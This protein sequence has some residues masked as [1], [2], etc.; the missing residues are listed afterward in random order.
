MAERTQAVDN[1]KKSGNWLKSALI[2]ARASGALRV[3]CAC[4][5]LWSISAVELSAQGDIAHT[6][7]PLDGPPVV[8]SQSLA[9]ASGNTL[10]ITLTASGRG[11][12][13]F[14]FPVGFAGS[15]TEFPTGN[16]GGMFSGTLPNLTYTPPP[17]YLGI[18]TLSYRAT[19]FAGPGQF[20][21]L[22]ITV[23]PPGTPQETP[24]A[25]KAA[26][27]LETVVKPALA[28]EW[29]DPAK[30]RNVLN[31]MQ[32]LTSSASIDRRDCK[33]LEELKGINPYSVPA[34]DLCVRAR[35]VKDPDPQTQIALQKRQGQYVAALGNPNDSGQPMEQGLQDFVD[36]LA[37]AN[38]LG[39]KAPG[40]EKVLFG[41]TDSL[42]DKIFQD[43]IVVMT[44]PLEGA[45][46]GGSEYLLSGPAA[47]LLIDNYF[48]AKDLDTAMYELLDAF[49][50][51]DPTIPT[52]SQQYAA[53]LEDLRAAFAMDSANLAKQVSDKIGAQKQP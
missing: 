42:I 22:Y 9:V 34:K 8:K 12:P 13:T 18:D 1:S 21:T 7:A 17:G 31:A 19:N 41:C 26:Q 37:K 43:P 44:R 38:N 10:A 11:N 2:A 49:P 27:G 25:P 16:P 23:L 48:K 32:L 14:S 4:I 28:S 47:L 51:Q 15:G 50:K 40:D 39:F 53:A 20:K 45:K 3:G 24:D 52:Y 46:K 6:C 30:V 36:I 5:F 35:F 29:T 33:V